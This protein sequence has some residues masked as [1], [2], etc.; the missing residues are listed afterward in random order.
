[1][2]ARALFVIVFLAAV[3]GQAPAAEY[4]PNE[5]LGELLSKTKSLSMPNNAGGHNILENSCLYKPD[6]SMS[7]STEFLDHCDLAGATA[8]FVAKYGPPAGTGQAPGG[9]TVLEYFLLFKENAYHVRVFLGCAEG[10]TETFAIVDC[11]NEKNR[12]MPGGPPGRHK[13]RP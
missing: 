12:Y 6:F 4:R 11:V 7:P 2:L 8:Q 3:V 10:K 13:P 5:P 9:K 1:M